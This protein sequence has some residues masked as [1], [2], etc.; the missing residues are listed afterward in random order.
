MFWVKATD[1]WDEFL[2]PQT[3]KNL[4]IWL[5]KRRQAALANQFACAGGADLKNRTRVNFIV[6][7]N[8]SRHNGGMIVSP[9]NLSVSYC[10]DIWGFSGEPSINPPWCRQIF[11]PD[12]PIIF[13]LGNKVFNKTLSLLPFFNCGDKFPPGV[14]ESGT[15]ES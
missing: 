8:A 12:H 6:R 15:Y 11:M 7:L 14:N 9:S 10:C 1:I 5:Q 2:K 13:S 3:G 4:G